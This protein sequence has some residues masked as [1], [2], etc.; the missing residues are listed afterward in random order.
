MGPLARGDDNGGI[1]FFGDITQRHGKVGRVGDDC[2]G[3]ADVI[4][5]GTLRR[6]AMLSFGADEFDL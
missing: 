6:G 5:G 2:S 1:H 4:N 3:L